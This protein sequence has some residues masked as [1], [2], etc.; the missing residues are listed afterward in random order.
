LKFS[1]KYGYTEIKVSELKVMRNK[2]KYFV[3][4]K[5]SEIKVMWRKGNGS[6][7]F[8]LGIWNKGKPYYIYYSILKKTYFMYQKVN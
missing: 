4:G 6:Y 5:K 2:G 1:L 7:E 8:F 3:S